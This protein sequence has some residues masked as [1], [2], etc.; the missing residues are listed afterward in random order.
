MLRHERRISKLGFKLIAGVDE[1]GRGSVAGPVVAAALIL[2]DVVFEARIDDSKRLTPHSRI[3]AYSEIIKKAWIGIGI[4]SEK[5]IDRVNIYNAT[6]MAMERSIANLSKNPD[7]VLIDGVLKVKIPCDKQCI[8]RGDSKSLTIAC[9]SIVAKVTRDN[10]MLKYHKKF[11]RYGF[12][13]HKGYG[14]KNHFLCIKRYGPS[15]IHRMSFS[16]LR[17]Y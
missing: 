10:M 11:P 9:A 6:V 15:V 5:I 3:A 8:I 14:T 7:F 13:Q 17:D 12:N 2:K 1:V 4:I 16:P